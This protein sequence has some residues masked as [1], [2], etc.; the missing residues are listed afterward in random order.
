MCK[1]CGGYFY[2]YENTSLPD[3]DP[4]KYTVACQ[5]CG[6]VYYSGGDTIA[7][8]N[9]LSSHAR[10]SPLGETLGVLVD[11]NTDVPSGKPALI[12]D[13]SGKMVPVTR[14]NAYQANKNRELCICCGKKT[15]ERP[16]FTGMVKY[17]DCIDKLSK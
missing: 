3:G 9:A 5:I 8:T 13:G 16:V 17:C 15:Y 6:S 11:R 1:K 2:F 7:A 4:G 14:S 10:T 12:N